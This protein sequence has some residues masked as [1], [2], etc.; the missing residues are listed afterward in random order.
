MAKSVLLFFAL[1]CFGCV[2]N[3]NSKALDFYIHKEP[4]SLD[5]L[6]F[7]YFANHQAFRSVYATLVNQ[8]SKFEVHPDLATKWFSLNGGRIWEFEVARGRKFQDGEPITPETIKKSIIRLG[9]QLALRK[10]RS[11]FF[12]SLLGGELLSRGVTDIDGIAVKD[13]KLILAF[14]TPMPRVLDFLASGMFGVVSHKDLNPDGSWRNPRSIIASGIYLLETFSDE[15]LVLKQWQD[16]RPGH[17][18][19]FKRVNVR[20]SGDP[21]T[22]D[23]YSGTSLDDKLEGFIFNGD[24]FSGIAYVHCYPWKNSKHPLSDATVRRKLRDYLHKIFASRADLSTNFFPGVYSQQTSTSSEV[25][26]EDFSFAPFS[27]VQMNKRFKIDEARKGAIKIVDGFVSSDLDYHLEPSSMRFKVDCRFS[28]TSILLESPREDIKF[29]IQAKEGIRLPD[30][31]G[32]LEKMI[33]EENFDLHKMNQIIWDDAV[34][35]PLAH[36]A[37]GYWTRKGVDVTSL[38]TSLSSMDLSWIGRAD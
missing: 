11:E 26:T 30:P 21:A 37:A 28:L 4:L 14:R 10:S 6:D 27:N 18:R 22:S 38:N 35:I 12:E 29:M 1:F 31:R 20:W 3:E 17:K 9:T 32:I 5:P 33:S 24:V 8:H 19:K 34:V 23:I 13:G 16:P 7:D 15:N 36:Y 2:M 25:I